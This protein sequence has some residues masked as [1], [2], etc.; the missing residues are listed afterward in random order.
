MKTNLYIPCLILAIV[1]LVIATAAAFSSQQAPPTEQWTK[2]DLTPYEALQGGPI[3]ASATPDDPAGIT[4]DTASL[5]GNAAVLHQFAELLT[6]LQRSQD[7]VDYHAVEQAKELLFK[8]LSETRTILNTKPQGKEIVSYLDERLGNANTQ[9]AWLKNRETIGKGIADASRQISET[10]SSVELERSIDKLK[11]LTQQFPEIAETQDDPNSGHALTPDESSRLGSL[12]LQAEFHRDFYSLKS[13]TGAPSKDAT[14]LN[15]VV[16]DWKTLIDEWDKCPDPNAHDDALIGAA[17]DLLQD[18]KMKWWRAKATE[19]SSP[20]DL[21]TV[22][23][24][25]LEE[26]RRIPGGFQAQHPVAVSVTEKWLNQCIPTLKPLPQID[27]GIEE[28]QT[29]AGMLKRGFYKAIKDGRGQYRF[30]Y[31]DRPGVILAAPKG[32]EQITPV[33][34]P[35]RPKHEDFYTRYSVA[36][37]ALLRAD[38]NGFLTNGGRL[39]FIKDIKQ[40]SKEFIAYKNSWPAAQ[41]PVF[42]WDS[43]AD[44][45]DGLFQDAWQ[46]VTDF[47]SAT[48]NSDDPLNQ[49]NP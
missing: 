10:E 45:W 48:N 25:W 22:I 18:A 36:R 11:Q 28:A 1:P 8:K 6:N 32:K 31:W 9:I 33:N 23:R 49:S 39:Q 24:D 20:D 13:K 40:I 14:Q 42:P 16:E 41:D 4:S 19:Q 46:K 15:Q 29:R 5:K 44:D 35:A 7:G 30:W 47:D 27:P 37:E 21:L 3:D 12:L 17:K 34:P 26:T 38:A 43:A 2:P